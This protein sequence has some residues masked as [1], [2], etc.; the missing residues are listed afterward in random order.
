MAGVLSER[1]GAV[2]LVR[3]NRPEVLNALNSQVMAELADAL[4]HADHDP[5]VA[6]L[7]IAG[8]GRAFAAG[9]DISQMATASATDLMELNHLALW[10]RIRQVKKPLVAAVHGFCLGGGLELAMCADLIVASE[11]A[12]FGQP[13]IKIGVM[14]GAGGTQML[15]RLV[16]AQLAM[17]MVLTGRMVEAAEAYKMGLVARLVPAGTA[18]AEAIVLA[19][20][21]AKMPRTAAQLAKEAVRR[22]AL[23]GLD[24]AFERKNFYL[25]FSTEDQKEGMAAFLEKRPPKF[26]GVSS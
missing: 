12:R 10:D 21:I 6:V 4:S 25:L 22:V 9:A 14:P 20:E 8:S 7:V 3:L 16:G 13:E 11:D 2:A 15:T 17:E 26:K 18:E 1:Q 23:S 24:Y 5:E 19:Q